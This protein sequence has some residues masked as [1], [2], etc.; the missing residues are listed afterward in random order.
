MLRRILDPESALSKIH[1]NFQTQRRA[2]DQCIDRLAKF[3]VKA[4]SGI[5]ADWHKL[6]ITSG[7]SR[8]SVI[9]VGNTVDARKPPGLR[10]GGE[11]C[12]VICEA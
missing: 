7:R 11:V 6:H 2:L 5:V 8:T 4:E 3:Y 12:A 9:A 1:S 10:A